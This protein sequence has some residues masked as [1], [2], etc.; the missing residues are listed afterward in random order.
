[1]PLNQIEIES[2]ILRLLDMLEEETGQYAR[3]A[4]DEA[5]KEARY[6]VAWA[7]AYLNAAG[8]VKEREAQ[9][10]LA[11]GKVYELTRVA[12]ALVRA[13]RER[14]TSLRTGLDSLRTLA[15]NLRFQT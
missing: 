10:D 15:A 7:T 9:A 12:D 5:S 8:P 14:L 11:T 4:E 2:E 3:L 6:K 1:M 13:K